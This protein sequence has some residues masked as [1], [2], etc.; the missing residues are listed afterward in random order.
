MTG[1]QKFY[2]QI[3]HGLYL[4]RLLNFAMFS[5]HEMVKQ[6][7]AEAMC[8]LVPHEKMLEYYRPKNWV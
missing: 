6:A 1:Y 2:V 7:A 8:N 5:E 3:I 4:N